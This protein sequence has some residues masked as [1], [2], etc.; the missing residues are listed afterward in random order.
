MSFTVLSAEPKLWKI[1]E[2]SFGSVG[3]GV[4]EN[5][6]AVVNG[7]TEGTTPEQP[8]NRRVLQVRYAH[9]PENPTNSAKARGAF[10]RVSFKNTREVAQA[11]NGMKLPRAI[12]YLVA[13][14]EHKEAVPMRRYAGGTG[15]TAQGEFNL[16]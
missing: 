8:A 15:R 6:G 13:V 10:L 16:C 5:I 2:R 3:N 1:W 7:A 11:I 14:K 9:N 12:A 4:A